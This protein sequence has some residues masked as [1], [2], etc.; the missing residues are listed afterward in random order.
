[1]SEKTREA[2]RILLSDI[3][4]TSMVPE[5]SRSADHLCQGEQQSG[6]NRNADEQNDEETNDYYKGVLLKTPDFAQRG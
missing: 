3:N 2:R 6:D 5:L 4:F 1:M